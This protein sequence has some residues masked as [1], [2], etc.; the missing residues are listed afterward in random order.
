M[1]MAGVV[2]VMAFV[3]RCGRVWR[4]HWLLADGCHRGSRSGFATKWEA[5]Q[6]ADAREVAERAAAAR[7]G[8]PGEG[9]GRAVTVGQWWDR[10]FPVQD[11]APGTLETYAQQYRHHIAP[12][13]AGVPVGQV[14]GLDLAGFS[15]DVREQGL[16]RSSVTVVM[17]VLRDLLSDAAAEGVIPVAPKDAR[18]GPDP[19]CAGLGAPRSGAGSGDCSVCVCAVAGAVRVDGGGRGVH[20]DAVG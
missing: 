7:R 18:A 17:S 4:G 11:L 9:E 6:F 5:K 20:R 12:R 3:E 19:A 8:E 1:C 13:F 14:T 10:W 15:R 2:I 16:S